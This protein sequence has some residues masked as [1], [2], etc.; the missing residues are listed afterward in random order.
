MTK[1]KFEQ[2]TC[3]TAKAV[4]LFMTA[5]FVF[6]GICQAAVSNS[7]NYKLYTV[8]S[9]GG[10]TNSGSAAYNSENSMGSPLGTAAAVGTSYKIYGGGLP[11]MNMPPDINITSYNDGLLIV[12]DTPTFT[13]NYND[14]DTDPQRYYQVQVSKDN[15]TTLTIDSGL[16]GSDDKNY[17]TPILPTD[18]AGVSY[19]WRVRVSDGFDYSGWQTAD[20]GFRLTSASM[21]V[22]IIWAKVPDTGENISASLWQKCGTP[23]LYWEYPVTGAD[24]SG[25]SYA[26]GSIPDDKIDTAGFSYQTPSD[27]LFDGIRQFNLKARNNAGIWS[28]TASFEIWI[29]RGNPLVGL[30]SPANGTII[31]TD[32]P[33]ISIDVR[34]ELSGVNP[35]AIV[36]KVNKSRVE[37]GYNENTRTVIYIP[38]VSLSEGDNVVSLETSD[39]VGNKTSPLIWSFVV[40]TEG[41]SGSI[42]INNQDAVT[43]SIYVNL[44]LSANDSTSGVK[45]MAVSNDGVFDTE[46]WEIFSD[47]KNNW[48]L[49]AISGTR[50][51]YVKFRDNAGNES[52]IFNDTIELIIVAPDTIITSGPNSLTA[53]K[54][55]LFTF[56]GTEPGCVFRWKFD[57][58]EWT[59]WTNENSAKKENLGEG[60]H[61]FKVQAAKDVNNNGDI[62]DDEVDPVPEERTW[63]IGDKNSTKPDKSKKKPFRFWKEE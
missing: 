62:E 20:K 10:G 43:N 19:R 24:I 8:I 7:E 34:D 58:E 61:Y 30:Y 63:T 56:K 13:W 59:D 39:I 1:S 27:L 47:R 15:F 54:Q 4:I 49:P 21:E 6:Y 41:P 38:S 60:N 48:A 3:F 51:V 42:I 33:T 9:N 25:Y 29:D 36:M 35:A 40:D 5:F 17:T 12:D 55:A 53:S 46:P 14:K 16:I 26:W 18:E 37:A 31:S 23:Y 11:T 22:P 2:Y 44:L 50:K 28:D 52:E 45:S 57:N 32:K